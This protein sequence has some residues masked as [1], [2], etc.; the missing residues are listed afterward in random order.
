MEKITILKPKTIPQTEIWSVQNSH[1]AWTVFHETFT[2]ATIHTAERNADWI[3]R[4]RTHLTGPKR[5]M[6]IEPGE[7][8]VTTK[9]IAGGSF[10]LF[11]LAPSLIEN[12]ARE[13]GMK[14]RFPHFSAADVS[15]ARSYTYFQKLHE[16][17]DRGDPA[18]RIETIFSRCIELVFSRFT[19]NKKSISCPSNRKGIYRARDFL[20]DHTANEITLEKIADIAGFSRFHFLRSFQKEFGISPHAY[21]TTVRLNR[22]LGQISEGIPLGQID[23][24]FADQSHLTRHFKK[25]F[26]ITP[27]QYAAS[28]H[29]PKPVRLTF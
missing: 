10:H 5:L 21:L 9:P 11:F 3:Y 8:H 12:L 25:A 27:G 1:R 7:L 13:F 29:R 14:T 17:I 2:L 6:L 28:I 26:G 4:R 15:D 18:L 24:G 23:S 16:S 22:V 20:V 19:E